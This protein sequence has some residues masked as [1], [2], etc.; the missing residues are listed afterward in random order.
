MILTVI[1]STKV[2]SKREEESVIQTE[3]FSTATA[4]RRRRVNPLR[5]SIREPR[6]SPP[7]IVVQFLLVNMMSFRETFR[8][9]REIIETS[10]LVIRVYA[11][12]ELNPSKASFLTDS[13]SWVEDSR[14]TLSRN[15]YRTRGKSCSRRF[16]GRRLRETDYLR[17]FNGGCTRIRGRVL[18]EA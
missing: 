13:W 2:P 17:S 5:M 6:D 18:L 10:S 15:C 1:S 11:R 12:N 7:P 9:S 3:K 4:V 14:S 16:N 8:L